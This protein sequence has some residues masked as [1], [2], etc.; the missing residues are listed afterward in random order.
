MSRPRKTPPPP[1][2]I[3]VVIVPRVLKIPDAARYLSATTW[4]VEELLRSGEIPSFIQGKERVVDRPELDKYV[5]RRNAEPAAK[6]T[7][8]VLNL[9]PMN[10][11]RAA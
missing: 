6:L 9:D 3:S 1:T 5:D 7:N 4:R 2:A 11:E 8:R 10:Q